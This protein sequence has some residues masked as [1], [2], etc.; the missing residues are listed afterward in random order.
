M[1]VAT[2]NI[3]TLIRAVSAI[4]PTTM[5][6]PGGTSA[7]RCAQLKL[8]NGE[9]QQV[10]AKTQKRM[11]MPLRLSPIPTGPRLPIINA[12]S[13]TR[14]GTQKRRFGSRPGPSP[15]H[16]SSRPFRP[17]MKSVL[18]WSI[19]AVKRCEI[20]TMPC[21]NCLNLLDPLL[22]DGAS[23]LREGFEPALQSKSHAFE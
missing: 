6:P 16:S 11:N 20:D 2:P 17:A 5:V 1:N 21:S 15:M 10:A 13:P 7:V 9:G 23:S 14:K 4:R 18:H 19:G 12:K 3:P 22:S 8:K